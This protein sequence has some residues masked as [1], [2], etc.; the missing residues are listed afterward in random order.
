MNPEHVELLKQG[1]K[2]IEAWQKKNPLT[3]FDL[4]GADLR[5]VEIEEFNLKFA[6]LSNSILIEAFAK[7]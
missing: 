4:S 1:Q 3:P 6:N 2:A 5:N 7:S